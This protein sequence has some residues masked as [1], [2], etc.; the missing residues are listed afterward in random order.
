M[1]V[2]CVALL[3]LS[4]DAL[5]QAPPKT[6]PTDA[7]LIKAAEA[8]GEV[9]EITADTPIDTTKPSS[10]E[11]EREELRVLPGSQGDALAGLRNLPGIAAAPA[12]DGVG[13][14]AVRGTAGESSLYLV[15]GVPV[16]I[17]M[18]FGNLQSVLPTEMIERIDFSPGGFGVEHGRATGG[19]ISIV[20]RQNQPDVWSGFAELSFINAAGLF[21]GP[22][23]KKH[24]VSLVAGFRRSLIDA[25][26]PVF[27]P[28]DGALTFRTPPRYYDAQARIDWVPSDKH[29]LSVTF[30]GSDDVT[31]FTVTA[32]DAHDPDVTGTLTGR[33]AFARVFARWHYKDESLSNLATVSVGT[34]VLE[35]YLN[36]THFY[37]VKPRVVYAR[38]E[39]VWKAHSA[40]SLRAGGDAELISG[41]L[42]A[43]VPLP[44]GEGT[45]DSS[46]TLDPHIDVD[47]DANDTRAA[48]WLATDIRPVRDVSVSIGARVDRFTRNKATI[49][50]P[51]VSATYQLSRKLA[52]RTAFGSYSRPLRL[53][54]SIRTDLKP[55]RGRHF[56][57]GLDASVVRG[58]RVSATGYF[59]T[60]SDLV[61]V[62]T[63]LMDDPLQSYRN[64][65]TGRS[66]GAELLV[67]VKRNRL[68]GWLSY[69]LSRSTRNDGAGR[70]KR[71]FDYDQT[72]NLTA[73]ASYRLGKW[74]FGGRF[75]LASGLPY[76]PVVGST[77]RSDHD[78]YTPIHAAHNSDRLALSHRLD[79]RVDRRFTVSGV[80]VD[81]YL[82]VAN[83]Y[84]NAQELG[85]SYNFDYS[86]RE[87]ETDV[88][89]LPSFGVRGSF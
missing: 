35:R 48:A 5:G 33:D 58:V 39:L 73:V 12:F 32:E 89:F 68:F 80:A 45:L 76:T 40:L 41:E 42:A 27:L 22:V 53:A 26:L 56:V 18:H 62:D 25:V 75:R 82:D 36:D 72:H 38:D 63:Q 4:A 67:R 10:E 87:A 31:G 88:P 59:T 65:G 19:V 24:N 55:E 83:A 28:D 69:T 49:V 84:A 54:E 13:D 11:V 57:G 51:R 30:L 2:T 85:Y 37:R 1:T 7:E 3:G 78:I 6:A 77:Y 47:T 20:T 66:V 50:Q 52:L 15:D 81:A 17:A 8:N 44:G 34:S 71:L 23:S 46:F 14:L 61:S 74:R 29:Q 70:M 43:K 60:L 21:R 79:L 64:Q 9:I 16:P 86:E